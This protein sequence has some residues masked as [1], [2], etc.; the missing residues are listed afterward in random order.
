MSMHEY[1]NAR[2]Q[3]IIFQGL[4]FF[5]MICE[6]ISLKHKRHYNII[7]MH[8]MKIGRCLKTNFLKST[9]IL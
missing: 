5:R 6:K 7:I 1:G 3:R 4:R 9:N 2:M 8:D